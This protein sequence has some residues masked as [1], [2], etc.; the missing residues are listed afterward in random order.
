MKSA[1]PGVFTA[2]LDISEL[3]KPD[4]SKLRSYSDLI[5]QF[6][7]TTWTS[8]LP[9]I[10]A[11]NGASPAGGCVLACC[12]DYR[13]MVDHPK[14]KIGLNEVK[15]GL[16]VPANF[17]GPMAS[18][19]GQRRAEY[20]CQTAKMFSGKEALEWGLIDELV[21]MEDFDPGIDFNNSAIYIIT[22]IFSTKKNMSRF[23]MNYS[24][25]PSR[26]KLRIGKDYQWKPDLKPRLVIESI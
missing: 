10:A 11:I 17:S 26:R 5:G 4:E 9:V 12:S 19:I 3:Y 2:G 23:L 14:F 21:S 25:K 6:F 15:M 20:A 24:F 13:I 22:M 1:K 8:K 18:L 16:S 7:L